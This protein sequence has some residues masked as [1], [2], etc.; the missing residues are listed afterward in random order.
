M[1]KIWYYSGY[2]GCY[3]SCITAECLKEMQCLVFDSVTVNE[4]KTE[5]K[6]ENKEVTYVFYHDQSC[7]ETVEIEDITGDLSDLEGSSLTLAEVSSKHG[8]FSEYSDSCTWTFYKFAT[9]KGY[10]DVRWFGYSNGYY[11]EA[12]DLKKIIK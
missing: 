10:V 1:S 5:L 12:V 6:F 2:D 3:K 8:C 4:D 7:C 9:I 11:S